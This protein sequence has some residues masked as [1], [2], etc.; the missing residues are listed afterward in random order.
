MTRPL[1]PETPMDRRQFLRRT[2]LASAWAVAGGSGFPLIASASSTAPAGSDLGAVRHVVFLMLENRSFDHYYGTY[3]GVRG[4]DDHA[5]DSLGV[6][7]QPDAANTTRSPV[8][9]QLP[10]HLNT[11]THLGECT[12]DI[13]HLWLSQHQS[14]HGGA[15]DGFVSTHTSPQN[16]GS[17]SGLLT[18]G[19]YTRA[20]L[21]FHY[22]LADAFT[23]CDHYFC[24]VLGPT[25]P[26][27]LMALSGSIDPSG[28]HGGP[29]LTTNSSPDILFSARWT[30][31]PEL[32]QDAGV[33]WKTYTPPGQGYIPT[34]PELG[35]GDAILQYFAAYRKPSSHLFQRAFLPTYPNDFVHDVRHNTLPSVS[36]IVPPNGFDEHPPAPPAYGAWL[37]SRVLSA[38]MSNR[39][40]WSRTVLFIT[41]DENGGFFDHVAPPTPPPGTP[42]E[43]V[44][45]TPL[46]AT[47]RG[48]AGP[49]GLGFRVPL[50][51]VSPFSRG[52]YL[53]SNVFDHTSL[54]RFLEARFG[55]RSH[56]ISAWRRSTVGNLVS[57]LRP[58]HANL[59]A[60]RLPA[61]SGYLGAAF[62]VDGCNPDD[63][64]ETNTLFRPYP[65]SPTQV[66]PTQEIGTL[67][68]LA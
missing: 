16:D 53:S 45:A 65:Q 32:L 42:G 2:G 12:H 18:M 25:H 38:L 26:N 28:T 51:V 3:K 23:I 17:V 61:T 54:I 30:S 67:H 47:A 24:S 43:F 50:L 57:T 62:R 36:W 29:V 10:F 39:E 22:A 20:D 40:V 68:P 15:M 9:V 55:I 52:G 58:P 13:T 6:F 64:A 19:Y 21:P 33:S 49:I 59:T 27:R 63:V 5:S 44:T 31:V 4:F 46:P 7:A 37:I 11:R 1:I 48:L 41:Y 14:W 8:G 60:P 66:M 35:F 56:E 34:A